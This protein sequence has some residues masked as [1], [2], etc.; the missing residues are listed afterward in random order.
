[1]GVVHSSSSSSNSNCW[2]SFISNAPVPWNF[3]SRFFGFHPLHNLL[4]LQFLIPLILVFEIFLDTENLYLNVDEMYYKSSDMIKCRDGSKKFSKAQLNDN[5]CD[6]PDG[7]DEPG[8]DFSLSSHCISFSF[9]NSLGLDLPQSYTYLVLTSIWVGHWVVI[10]IA[11]TAVV[12]YRRI[13]I[14]LYPR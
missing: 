6:C 4:N 14:H 1:M 2:I 9:F 10:E 8:I 5:F 3:S 7:T 13:T 11:E 12:A